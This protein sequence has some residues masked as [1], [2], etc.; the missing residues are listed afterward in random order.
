MQLCLAIQNID[1][2][3]GQTMWP[4]V[5]IWHEGNSRNSQ[6]HVLFMTILAKEAE[7]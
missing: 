7:N 4:K 2:I 3:K 6:T 1:G 5:I